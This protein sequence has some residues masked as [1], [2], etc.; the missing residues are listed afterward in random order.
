MVYTIEH[1]EGSGVRR[2]VQNLRRWSGN[3]LRGGARGIALGPRRTGLFI[4]WCLVDQRLAM[5]TMLVGPMLGL[6]GAVLLSPAV[7]LAYLLWVGITRLGQAMVLFGYMREVSLAV[8]L[9]LYVNQLVTTCVK[10]YTLF[11]LGRQRWANRGDQNTGFGDGLAGRVRGAVASCLTLV[12]MGV[13]VLAIASFSGLARL[14][15]LYTV[16]ALLLAATP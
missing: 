15:S 11:R 13:L 14:P 3:T 12:A 7:L 6:I 5:W 2:M 8:P 4:W 9:L 16:H 10:V 1:I